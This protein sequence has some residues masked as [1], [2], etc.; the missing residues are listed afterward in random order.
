MTIF[1]YMK[2]CEVTLSGKKFLFHC[3]AFLKKKK[4]YS[5]TAKDLA[6]RLSEAFC[7][8]SISTLHRGNQKWSTFSTIK[9]I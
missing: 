5:L 9:Y 8:R 1:G 7:V 4:A 6:K 3:F 2:L